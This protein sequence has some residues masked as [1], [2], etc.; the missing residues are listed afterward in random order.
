MLTAKAVREVLISCLYR[1]DEDTSGVV[2]VDGVMI[3]VGFHPERLE[4]ARPRI[5]ELLKELP[6]AFKDTGGGGASFLNACVTKD[7]VQWGEHSNID[8]LLCLGLAA[9]L[10]SFP[11]PRD[12]WEVLPGGMPYFCVRTHMEPKHLDK[13]ETEDGVYSELQV[14]Q[15]GAGF[16]IGRLF[17][18][19]DGLVEPGSRESC[20]YPNQETAEAALRTE[21]FHREAEEL[22][23]LYRSVPKPVP[24]QGGVQDGADAEG[25][26]PGEDKEGSA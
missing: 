8:E 6:D 22:E 25:P 16:Y 13:I 4:A 21:C 18:G 7:K 9:R 24:K 3:K 14:L 2:P 17:T 20:Y 15:S 11:I 12:L 19:T 23:L 10:V 1:E 5:L 26:D